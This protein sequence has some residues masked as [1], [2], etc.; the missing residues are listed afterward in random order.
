MSWRAGTWRQGVLVGRTVS[1]LTQD[2]PGPTSDLENLGDPRQGAERLAAP[3]SG[4][5]TLRT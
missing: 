2:V 5:A 1:A 3:K 4:P